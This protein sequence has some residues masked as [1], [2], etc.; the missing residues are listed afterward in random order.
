VDGHSYHDH[1]KRDFQVSKKGG[2]LHK[3]TRSGQNRESKGDG[4]A[5]RT[6]FMKCCMYMYHCTCV[7]ASN[8]CCV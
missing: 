3:G 1:Q 6:I 4:L 2:S 7:L 8:E 5:G